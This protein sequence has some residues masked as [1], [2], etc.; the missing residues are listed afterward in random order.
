MLKILKELN[1]LA[2]ASL[3]CVQGKLWKALYNGGSFA[4]IN[5]SVK[6]KNLEL[7]LDT[8]VVTH[9][10]ILIKKREDLIKL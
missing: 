10:R 4:P 1:L 5:F 6:D 9:C 2:Q 8:E 7:Y 3:K